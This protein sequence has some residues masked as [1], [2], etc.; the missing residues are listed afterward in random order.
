MLQLLCRTTNL[1]WTSTE[2]PNWSARNSRRKKPKLE[3]KNYPKA[4]WDKFSQDEKD[5]ITAMLKAD[6]EAKKRKA[7]TLKADNE[8]ETK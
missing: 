6:K 5:K 7:A 3:A 2:F 1:L 8:E 4:K